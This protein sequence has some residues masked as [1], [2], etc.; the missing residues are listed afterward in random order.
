MIQGFSRWIFLYR[1]YTVNHPDS[2]EILSTILLCQFQFLM[3]R[4]NSYRNHSSKSFHTMSW[5][6]V[7]AGWEWRNLGPGWRLPGP[8]YH[9]VLLS[10]SMMSCTIS[11]LSLRRPMCFPGFPLTC[12]C[13]F[14]FLGSYILENHAKSFECIVVSQCLIAT[15]SCWN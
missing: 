7:I 8:R 3:N 4:F 9:F 6:G 5:L 12:W 15:W 2:K 13:F 1:V 14:L 10:T 11:F